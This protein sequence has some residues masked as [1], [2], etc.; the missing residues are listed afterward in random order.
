MAPARRLAYGPL[1]SRVDTEK[2]SWPN[3]PPLPAAHSSSAVP[4]PCSPSRRLLRAGSQGRPS[5]SRAGT[6]SIARSRSR[7]RRNG[8]GAPRRSACT[9][10]CDRT[11]A[12]PQCQAANLIL[13]RSDACTSPSSAAVNKPYCLDEALG[14]FCNL[15]GSIISGTL[16]FADVQAQIDDGRPL[17]TR[18]AWSGGGAHFMVIEGYRAAATPWVAIRDPIYGESDLTYA[19]SCTAYPGTG[20]W[21]HSYTTKSHRIRILDLATAAAGSVTAVSR[22]P[23]LLDV[24]AVDKEG[25]VKSAASD[26]STGHGR[27][28]GWWHLQGGMAKPGARVACVARQPDLLEIFV[29]GT[30]GGIYTA[31]WD[32]SQAAGD[33]RGW[34]RIGSLSCRQTPA[35]RRW[36][37][38]RTSS[39]S[40]SSTRRAA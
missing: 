37:A 27:W 22:K 19:S 35:S 13:G 24:F 12:T 26:L 23:Q 40:S 8:A 32:A 4:C 11:D 2:T 39:T 9:S 5:S 16:A 31:A 7:S 30:G 15:N 25:R 14:D 38:I 1:P 36:H 21:S 17:G 33:W 34:W 6:G 18:I 28:R 20:S 3:D 10:F 29:V